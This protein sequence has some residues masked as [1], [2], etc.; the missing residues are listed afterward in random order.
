MGADVGA[1]LSHLFGNQRELKVLIITYYWPPA[2]GSGVQR[3]LKFAKY[4]PDFGVTPIVYTVKNPD[5][6]IVDETLASEVAE[7]LQVI[8]GSIVE[9]NQIFSRFNSREKES[10]AGFLDSNPSAFGKIMQYVRANYFIPDARRF[11]VKPSVKRLKKWIPENGIDLVITTGP[12]H[13][14]HLIGLQLKAITGVKWLADFRDPWTNIDYFHNLP[15]NRRARNR[16]LQLETEV[17]TKADRVVVVGNSMKEEFSDRCDRISV[18]TNGFDA[19]DNKERQRLDAKFSISHIGMMNADRNP[20]IFWN[21]LQE[22]VS[23]SEDFARDL[24]VK[25][26]GRCVDDVYESVARAG[27]TDH[28]SFVSYLPHE[29]VLRFQSAS[30]VLLIA[31]NNVPSAR[32][33]ITGKVFEYLQS[34]RPV[35][36]I[37][38]EDGD[39][40][41]ILSRSGAGKMIGFDRQSE[42]KELIWRHYQKFKMNDLKTSST[43]IAQYERRNLTGKLVHLIHELVE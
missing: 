10:S 17:L 31:V 29:E 26:I 12:P 15:M 3:W 1:T 33:I 27:L 37:G 11:W 4:L 39:L 41:D 36:G 25:L 6:P 30:Q 23:E 9:P 8:R 22:L 35:I 2:G 14:L 28:V 20:Q 5:Y 38:P 18:I 24:Q 32:A 43:D 42:L 13:S 7:D 21:A 19:A 40:S 34:Q 16:H